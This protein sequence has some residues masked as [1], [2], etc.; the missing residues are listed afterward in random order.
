M[1]K[2]YTGRMYMSKTELAALIKKYDVSEL[3]D[4]LNEINSYYVGRA[5]LSKKELAE[6]G[7]KYGWD[8]SDLM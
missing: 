8:V 6:L 3:Q 5:Y 4:F 2:F 1:K 7:L